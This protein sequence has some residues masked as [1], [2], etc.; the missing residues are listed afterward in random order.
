MAIY[1]VI[2]LETAVHVSGCRLTFWQD[3][4]V[5]VVVVV[6]V[7]IVVVIVVVVFVFIIIMSP[8][9]ND[10][11][12]FVNVDP[13][14]LVVVLDQWKNDRSFAGDIGG[15]RSGGGSNSGGG[16]GIGGR[17]GQGIVGYPPRYPLLIIFVKGNCFP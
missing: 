11:V 14:V 5:V 4:T 13:A 1:L 8:V 7:V 3:S 16:G 2:L 12:V 6:V 17:S 9:V 10:V 15:G